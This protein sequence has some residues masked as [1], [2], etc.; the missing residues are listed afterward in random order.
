MLKVLIVDDQATMRFLVSY[1]LKNYF[2]VEIHE[3]DSVSQAKKF[4]SSKKF[5]L[6]ISDHWMD[7]GLVL[8]IAKFIEQDLKITIPIIFFSSDKDVIAKYNYEKKYAA[9]L[10]PELSSIVDAIKNLGFQ[11]GKYK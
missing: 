7:D 1:K 11:K 4:L 5:D 2:D 6:I 10:K 8:D 9:I 3:A